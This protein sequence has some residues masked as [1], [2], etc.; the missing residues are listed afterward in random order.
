MTTD[1]DLFSEKKTFRL[2]FNSMKQI[3]WK[4]VFVAI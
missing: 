4:L 1:N 3:D 2:H